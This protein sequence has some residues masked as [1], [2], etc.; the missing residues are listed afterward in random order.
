MNTPLC[1]EKPFHCYTY[2]LQ[3]C[4]SMNLF[5]M[6]KRRNTFFFCFPKISHMKKNFPNSELFK[7][8]E[9]DMHKLQIRIC[10]NLFFFFFY[11]NTA[12]GNS[13]HYSISMSL[14]MRDMYVQSFPTQLCCAFHGSFIIVI[15][16]MGK[17]FKNESF[18]SNLPSSTWT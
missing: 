9:D 14:T 10:I 2:T 3:H 8:L 18:L 5:K 6:M 7:G 17:K 4:P 13:C 12:M 11:P 15:P 16:E 1:P